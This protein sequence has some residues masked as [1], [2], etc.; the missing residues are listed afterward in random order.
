MGFSVGRCS[1]DGHRPSSN[2]SYGTVTVIHNGTVK[3]TGSSGIKSVWTGTGDVY[4]IFGRSED[5]GKHEFRVT[6][7]V[8]TCNSF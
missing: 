6:G 8:Q 4:V 3:I 1:F 7:T 5:V 2:S